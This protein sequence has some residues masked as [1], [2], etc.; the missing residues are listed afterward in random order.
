MTSHEC[1]ATFAQR[2]V[3]S[4]KEE[5]ASAQASCW[6]GKG[7]APLPRQQ[8]KRRRTPLFTALT[9]TAVATTTTVAA[10]VATIA[11]TATTTEA[12]AAAAAGG[13]LGLVDADGATLW[14]GEARQDDE[15]L[16]EA[17]TVAALLHACMHCRPANLYA[18]MQGRSVHC[19]CFV[20]P[21]APAVRQRVRTAC[22]HAHH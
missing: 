19:C 13:G 6:D 8:A 2:Y 16:D 10:T 15:S 17:C 11:S 7:E 14:R 12:T 21:G 20:R 1:P 4:H 3:A 22:R 18:C 9:A 5:A